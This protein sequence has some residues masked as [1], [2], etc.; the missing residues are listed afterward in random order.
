MNTARNMPWP[1]IL[2]EGAAIIASILLAFWIQAWWE[3][4]QARSEERATLSA[5]LLEFRDIRDSVDG[6]RIYN[7]AIRDSVLEL[8]RF[9]QGQGKELTEADIDRLLA[10]LWWN[11]ELSPVSAPTLHS[12]VASGDL[13]LVSNAELRRD[14]GAWPVTLGHLADTLQRDNDFFTERLMPFLAENSSLIQIRAAEDHAPGNPE[15]EYDA[16]GVVQPKESVSHSELLANTQFLNI[17][18]EREVWLTDILTMGLA[19]IDEDLDETIEMLESEL[20]V[21]VSNQN[22]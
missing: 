11:Q 8:L 18:S 22:P 14:L 13:T 19:G 15:D 21:H 6:N 17:L 2:A 7:S 10:D 20:A 1:R 3:G 16:T 12:I 9:S 4:Q 5:L